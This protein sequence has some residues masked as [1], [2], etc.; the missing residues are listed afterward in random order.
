MAGEKKGGRL[1]LMPRRKPDQ[2]ILP[3]RVA[4]DQKVLSGLVARWSDLVSVV[5]DLT[6]IVPSYLFCVHMVPGR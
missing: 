1:P 3:S 4:E 5:L 2:G 6:P